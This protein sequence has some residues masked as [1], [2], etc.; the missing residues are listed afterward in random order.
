M[1]TTTKEQHKTIPFEDIRNAFYVYCDMIERHGKGREGTS[2]PSFYIGCVILSSIAC[3]VGLKALLAYE[4]KPS[5]GHDLYDLFYKLSPQIQTV[6][7]QDTNYNVERFN[8]ALLESKNNFIKWRYYYE[9]TNLFV[10]YDFILKFFCAIKVNLDTKKEVCRNK[11]CTSF[12][13]SITKEKFD[14]FKQRYF[15]DFF[16]LCVPCI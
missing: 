6:I 8:K 1:K 16:D 7:I 4:N 11:R 5:H 3:E 12:F 14:I 15:E 9:N 2:I 10:N 13:S